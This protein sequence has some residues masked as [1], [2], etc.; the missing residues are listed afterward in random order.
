[1]MPLKGALPL[2]LY[3]TEKLCSTHKPTPNKVF[4]KKRKRKKIFLFIRHLAE[5]LV[6]AEDDDEDFADELEVVDDAVVVDARED[7]EEDVD[8]DDDEVGEE[9]EEDVDGEVDEEAPPAAAVP[10]PLTW[11]TSRSSRTM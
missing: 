6:E 8:D 9:G 3:T 4:L 7:E 2:L 1:M 5:V 11:M 10:P